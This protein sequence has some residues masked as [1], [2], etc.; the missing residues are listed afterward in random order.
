MFLLGATRGT[1]PLPPRLRNFHHRF[2]R[3]TGLGRRG[4]RTKM[5]DPA[6]DQVSG[7]TARGPVRATGKPKLL[8][9]SVLLYVGEYSR[10][11]AVATSFAASQTLF[12]TQ[13]VF[14]SHTL[15]ASDV[16]TAREDI[17]L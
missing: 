15:F 12:F 5:P 10:G 17:E 13:C 16:F 11:A 8:C 3:K 14:T 4:L 6:A 1:R 7:I 9:S 2:A